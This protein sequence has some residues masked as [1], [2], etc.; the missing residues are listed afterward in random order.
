MGNLTV[1]QKI[2]FF[3]YRVFDPSGFLFNML[4]EIGKPFRVLFYISFSLFFFGFLLLL[5]WAVKS[6]YPNMAHSPI[7]ISSGNLFIALS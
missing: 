3:W 6:L 2:A 4:K 7:L 5:L 1:S